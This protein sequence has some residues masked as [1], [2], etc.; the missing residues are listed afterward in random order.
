MPKLGGVRRFCWVVQSFLSTIV[1]A[2][3]PGRARSISRQL[4]PEFLVAITLSSVSTPDIVHATFRNLVGSI[5]AD[6]SLLSAAHC[7]K[8]SF[9]TP[10]IS[11][12]ST[13]SVVAISAAFYLAV[14][15]LASC[16]R[17]NPPPRSA[18]LTS[19]SAMSVE[20][21]VF[22]AYALSSGDSKTAPATK[23]AAVI[24]HLSLG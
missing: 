22:A 20:N 23:A 24:P 12:P 4:L 3:L 17:V 8:S 10:C 21:T 2:P 14:L 13:A 5:F 18:T 16:H 9:V 11:E 15:Y 7:P 6:D 1:V 19:P